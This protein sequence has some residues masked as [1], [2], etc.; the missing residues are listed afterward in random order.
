MSARI[1]RLRGKILIEDNGYSLVKIYAAA[2]MPFKLALWE[3]IGKLI[4][5]QN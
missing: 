3:F 2:Y 5:A 1:K 4:T